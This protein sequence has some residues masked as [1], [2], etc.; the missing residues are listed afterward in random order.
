MIP[1]TH[2]GKEI[3]GHDDFTDDVVE[4]K[5]NQRNFLW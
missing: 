2:N 4:K 1:W 5:Y 3:T